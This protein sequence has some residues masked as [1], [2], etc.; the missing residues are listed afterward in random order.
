M[1]VCEKKIAM[2]EGHF[3][4]HRHYFINPNG[5]NMRK[6]VPN[7]MFKF[8]DNPTVNESEIGII[9]LLEQVWVYVIKKRILGE[10]KD[11]QIWKKKERRSKCKT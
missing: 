11:K 9:V 4:H 8:H 3:P 10:G 6:W 5:E 2:C 7:P 1:G